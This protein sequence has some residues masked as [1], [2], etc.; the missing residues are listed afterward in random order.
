MKLKAKHP[1]LFLVPT[2]DI[3]QCWISHLIRP[4]KY[5]NDCLKL[6]GSVIPHEFLLSEEQKQYFSIALQQTSELYKQ[7]YNEKYCDFPSEIGVEKW[8]FSIG[9]FSPMA[10]LRPVAN[11]SMDAIAILPNVANFQNPFR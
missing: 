2:Y 7:E 1:D 8:R 6:Y 3:E 9:P 11:Y 4:L 5:R 10:D